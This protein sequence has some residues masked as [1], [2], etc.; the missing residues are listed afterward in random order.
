[1]GLAKDLIISECDKSLQM[2]GINTIDMLVT[3]IDDRRVPCEET[4]G[5]LNELVD[6]GNEKQMEDYFGYMNVELSEDDMKRLN[7]AGI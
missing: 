4:L 2:L 6:A 5:V 7:E 3:H 1:M